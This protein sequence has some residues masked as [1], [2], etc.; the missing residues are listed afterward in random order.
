MLVGHLAVGFLAKRSEPVLSLGTCL[1][2]PLLSDL[3]LFVFVISGRE[4][5]AFGAGAGAA[6]YLRAIDIGYSHSLLMTAVWAAL[7]GGGFYLWRRSAR[8]S[9]IL[10]AGVL[11]HWLLDVVSHVPDMPLAPGLNTHVGLGLWTSIPATLVLEGGLWIGAL[12]LYAR[13]R[14]RVGVIFWLVLGAGSVVLT[15]AWLQNIM[16]PP[17]PNPRTAPL[18]S[19][20]FFTLVVLWGFW[21]NRLDRPAPVSDRPRR[22]E[23]HINDD[24]KHTTRT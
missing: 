14:P 9:V 7:F 15:L 2:A 1:F 10:F 16:G 23:E 22:H 8:G 21:L 5:I 24:T 19:L 6:A 17:P 18:A 11:S 3:L 13:T 12:V 4:H 20:I